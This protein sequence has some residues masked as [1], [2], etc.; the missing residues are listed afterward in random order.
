MSMD[1]NVKFSALPLVLKSEQMWPTRS[2]YK[3]AFS[4]TVEVPAE[5]RKKLRH[6]APFIFRETAASSEQEGLFKPASPE[7]DLSSP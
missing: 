3:K 7:V 5:V 2:L 1:P 4:L 6:V